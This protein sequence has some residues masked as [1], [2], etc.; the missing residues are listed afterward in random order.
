MIFR[1]SGSKWKVIEKLK[2]LPIHK[3]IVEGYLGSGAFSLSNSAPALGID[4]NPNIIDIWNFLKETTIERLYELE[5]I[6]EEAVQKAIDNKPD[7]RTLGLSKGEELYFRVNVTGIYVGQLSSWKIYPKWKLPIEKTIKD[8]ERLKNIEVLLGKVH[9]DY[10]EQDGD[11]VFLD[12]PYIGTKG[13]YKSNGKKGIE[14]SYNNQ[15][16][17][18]LISKLSCPIILTYGTDAPLTF[19]QYKWEEVLRKKVPLIRTGGT[20]ERI[21]HVTYINWK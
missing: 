2:Q 20:V 7:V 6:R 14:E 4:V 16:T 5:K 9:L 3:R 11:L 18:D 17:I 12:P 13:N 8:L 10:K 1:Y 15:D 21:E 19:P